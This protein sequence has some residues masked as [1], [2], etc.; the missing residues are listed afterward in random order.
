MFRMAY[1]PLP[2]IHRVQCD[3]TVPLRLLLYL[4]NQ[5]WICPQHL[6]IL[7]HQLGQAA[8]KMPGLELVRSSESN[9]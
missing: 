8:G 2:C 5:Y 1:H 7:C 6:P 3:Q 4:V 9:S